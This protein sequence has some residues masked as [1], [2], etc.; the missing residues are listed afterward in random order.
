MNSYRWSSYRGYIDKLCEFDFVEYDPVLAFTGL[1][2]RSA[3]AKMLC[4][5]AG[6]TQRGA[7]KVLNIQSGSAVSNQLRKLN[8]I[9]DDSPDIRDEVASIDDAL[10]KK[11]C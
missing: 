4:K 9:V 1:T 6:L 8:R 5:Y 10:N 2:R 11:L 3:A 7:A